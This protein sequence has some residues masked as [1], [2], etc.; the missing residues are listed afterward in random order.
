VRCGLFLLFLL[1]LLSRLFAVAG[2][3]S[4][5]AQLLVRLYPAAFTLLP[6]SARALVA[7]AACCV[8]A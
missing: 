6:T 2:L 8:G 1:N 5:G 4:G 7:G 3:P